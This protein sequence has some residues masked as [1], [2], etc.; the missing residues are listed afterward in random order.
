[1]IDFI[2]VHYRDK[3]Y[4]ESFILNP[5][6]FEDIYSKL[7]FHTGEVMFPYKTSLLNMEITVNEKSGYVKNSLHK[8]YNVLL[9]NDNHNYNDFGYSDI[10]RTIAYLE[11]KIIDIT[12]NPLT[13]FEFGLNIKVPHSAETLISKNVLMH[14]LERHTTTNKYKGKGYLMAFAHYNYIIKIYDKAKQYQVAENIL[15]FEIK[16]TSSKEF[17]PLGVYNVNDL[18]NRDVLNTLFIYLLKRFDEL[19]IVDDFTEETIPESDFNKLSIYS[20]FSYWQKFEKLSRQSKMNHKKRFNSL[21]EK[22][23]LLQTKAMLRNLLVEKFNHLIN[24]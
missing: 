22:N 7:H 21:L 18:R 10:M 11:S 23:N 9:T 14:N 15:R 5:D 13:Q 6:N 3:S 1:M 2:R 19:I 8:L 20:S 12:L 24:H 16:F 4:L 17:N